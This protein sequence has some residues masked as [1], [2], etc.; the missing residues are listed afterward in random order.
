MGLE[1]KPL[2][3]GAEPSAEG[4]AGRYSGVFL[5]EDIEEMGVSKGRL[6][7]VKLLSSRSRIC[8]ATG[9]NVAGAAL[10]GVKPPALTGVKPEVTGGG[11]GGAEMGVGMAI[12]IGIAAGELSAGE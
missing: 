4:A 9:V 11:G 3:T 10:T 1:V 2:T 12:G 5:A 8:I 6:E 7:G